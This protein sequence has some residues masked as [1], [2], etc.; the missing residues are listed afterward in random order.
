VVSS[1]SV[2]TG[3][4]ESSE[5]K[6]IWKETVLCFRVVHCPDIPWRNLGDPRTILLEVHM[7]VEIQTGYYPNTSPQYSVS[8]RTSC[9]VVSCRLEV[10]EAIRIALSYRAIHTCRCYCNCYMEA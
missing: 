5:S 6:R 3:P 7:S 10:F 2:L 4:E 1:V 8:F 9:S